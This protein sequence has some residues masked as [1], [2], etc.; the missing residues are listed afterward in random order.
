VPLSRRLCYLLGSLALLSA[1]STQQPVPSA[2]DDWIQHRETVAAL[3]NW[4]FSGKVAI[5]TA[6]SADSAR[7]HWLQQG[8]QLRL[9]ISGPVGLKKLIFERD[10]TNLKV[11]RN[12]QWQPLQSVAGALE[13]ELGWPLPLDLLSWWLRGLP[14]PEVAITSHHLEDGRLQ[15]LG[16]DGWTL[17]YLTYATVN[18]INLPS[19]IRFQRDDVSGK[20]LLKRWKLPGADV[21]EPRADIEKP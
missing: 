12:K 13:A 8:E 16:Q 15:E 21:E 4:E 18:G 2:A 3:S 11:F 19:S 10:G 6:A 5:K 1:C 20:I 7:L 9:E 17:N 14:A